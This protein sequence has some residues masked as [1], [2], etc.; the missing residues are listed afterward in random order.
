MNNNITILNR[1]LKLAC[2]AELPNR[3]AKAA[4]NEQLA[5]DQN[6][7]TKEIIR[8]YKRWAL[9]GAGLMI[10]GNVMIARTA[11]VLPRD[12]VIED[13]RDLPLLQEWAVASIAQGGHIWMQ[14]NHPGRQSPIYLSPQPVAPSSIPLQLSEK[15]FAQPRALTEA[16]I[17][18]LIERHIYTAK[19]A[20]KAGFTGVQIHAAHG[21]LINQFLSPL[22]NQRH[23]DWGGTPEKRMRF[24]LEV[25][26]GIR[27]SLGQDFP[28][29][30]KLNSADFQRGG[31][32]EE[33]SI[34]VVQ[35]LEQVG[36]DLIEISGGTY[37][38][39]AMM[40]QTDIAQKESTR[41]REAYFLEY[42]RK[43]RSSISLPIML[44]GGFRSA[45]AMA[46]AIEEGSVDVIGLARPLAIAPNLPIELLTN[47]T[48]GITLQPQIA[49]T[50]DLDQQG[51]LE[52]IWYTQQ[53]HQLA[54]EDKSA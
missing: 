9:G 28:I 13:E 35:V 34:N 7:P 25:Y 17:K 51:M 16:E 40:G 19:I 45:D 10:T 43:V 38:K 11:L 21:Y 24:L 12:V 1:P 39:L 36:V 22:S 15:E 3:I 54:A 44:T 2:G 41:Q 32:T 30:V 50:N 23:D 52:I 33:E 27:N 47:R 49:Q 48:S 31:F 4:M 6:S 20:K 29:S 8:L 18:H 46:Q 26:Q 5:D 14:I 42:V 53:I 37:E